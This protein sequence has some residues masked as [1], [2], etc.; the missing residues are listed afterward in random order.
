[1]SVIQNSFDTMSQI[2]KHEAAELLFL[3]K[4]KEQRKAA[5]LLRKQITVKQEANL[6]EISES[7]NEDLPRDFMALPQTLSMSSMI[8][9]IT[10]QVTEV[11]TPPPVTDL[12]VPS[13]PVKKK[14][15]PEHLQKLKEGREKKRLQKQQEKE[16]QV[17]VKRTLDFLAE[18]D[19][20]IG[21][22]VAPPTA[23]TTDVPVAPPVAPTTDAPI[24]AVPTT[25]R[26]PHGNQDS[27]TLEVRKRISQ[28]KISCERMQEINRYLIINNVPIKPANT[29][30]WG[31]TKA[32]EF[33]RIA[34]VFGNEVMT[35]PFAN[36]ND[37]FA[38]L[39]SKGYTGTFPEKE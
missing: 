12:V 7:N 25:I 29:K 2:E 24:T 6:I 39:Q 31:Y 1:M 4:A 15:S 22:P 36:E 37:L 20:I 19:E 34:R 9:L 17:E 5:N 16:K 13:A 38:F 23:P 14:L 10:P 35:T 27:D 3:K 21:V 26:N 11:V 30:Q 28:S 18:L 8:D 32:S 33:D